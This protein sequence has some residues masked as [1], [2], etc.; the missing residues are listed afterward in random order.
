MFERPHDVNGETWR[1]DCK[2]GVQRFDEPCW[3]GRVHHF[4]AVE[5]DLY[6]EMLK[7][8]KTKVA[9]FRDPIDRL[10]SAY[11]SKVACAD[12]ATIDVE[13]YVALTQRCRSRGFVKRVTT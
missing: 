3:K 12:E 6:K 1:E 11:K 2:L 4:N 8:V 5:V 10:L 13:G 7:K 9:I